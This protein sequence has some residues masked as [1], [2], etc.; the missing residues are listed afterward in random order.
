[1]NQKLKEDSLW[2]Y[3]QS[4]MQENMATARLASVAIQ[5]VNYIVSESIKAVAEEIK[6][7]VHTICR[8]NSTTEQV[9]RKA[10]DVG[11]VVT[12]A[13][14]QPVIQMGNKLL[15][16]TGIKKAANKIH[17]VYVHTRD[18]TMPNLLEQEFLIPRK[19]S[20]QYVQDAV[21]IPPALMRGMGIVAQRSYAAVK[22]V[23]AAS[24]LS[25]TAQ[26]KTIIQAGGITKSV[27]PKISLHHPSNTR[28]QASNAKASRKAQPL[29][30]YVPRIKEKVVKFIKDESGYVKLPI[31]RE[32]FLKAFLELDY[33]IKNGGKGSHLK[34][35]KANSP[36]VVIPLSKELVKGTAQNLMRIYEK[37]KKIQCLAESPSGLTKIPKSI[38]GASHVK[39]LP[40]R[41]DYSKDY[42]AAKH[43]FTLAKEFN[44]NLSKDLFVVQYHSSNPLH[45]SRSYK[46]FMPISEAN[47]HL[48]INDI[49]NAITKLSSYGEVTEVSLARI[50]AGEPVRFL[51]GRAKEQ[52]DLL[53]S[54]VRPG[55][56]VQY[57]FFDFDLKWIIQTKTLP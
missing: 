16:E 55:G 49:K 32:F 20:R 53:T 14:T 23:K 26:K 56:G 2:V 46:W 51:H 6:D 11:K 39:P 17:N 37:A 19:M 4:K 1:M 35:T 9:C 27:H 30:I 3:K 50:P 34:L 42:F 13:V 57:R 45:H 8:I 25:K 24:S 54:E 5:G 52:V 18:Y 28:N 31:E 22:A 44:G 40:H 48:T 41:I 43:N 15:E 38:K 29:S 33:R 36:M 10:A 12:K 7:S 21:R 47:K